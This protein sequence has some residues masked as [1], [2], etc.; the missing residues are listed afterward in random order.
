MGKEQLSDRVIPY[1]QRKDNYQPNVLTTAKRAYTLNEQR[2]FFFIVNQ[3]NHLETYNPDQNLIFRI[4]IA[5]ISKSVDYKELKNLCKTFKDKGLYQKDENDVFQSMTIFPWIEYNGKSGIIEIMMLSKAIPFFVNLG[6]EY[7]RYNVQIML[8]LSS[9]YSQRIFE[10]LRMFQGRKRHEFVVDFIELKESL[11]CEKYTYK[12]FRIN[13]LEV[14]QKELFEKAGISFNFDTGSKQR[15]IDKIYF[16]IITWQEITTDEVSREIA[17]YKA[18]PEINQYNGV[19][20]ILKS[21]YTFNDDQIKTI[22]NDSKLREKFIEVDSLIEYGKVKIS[23][24]PTKY[25]AKVLGFD[26]ILVEKKKKIKGG[27]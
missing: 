2:L 20:M 6:K 21:K 16:K 7:T 27:I 26:K 3:F 25:M 10:L 14:A 22:V 17:N 18:A 13:V 9:K 1:T 19:T 12:D 4:P 23:K 24:T 8:S 15:G 11:S 5:E